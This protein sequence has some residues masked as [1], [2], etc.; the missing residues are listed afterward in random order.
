VLATIHPVLIIWLAIGVAMLI[1]NRRISEATSAGQKAF[2]D[3]L[4]VRWLQRWTDFVLRPWLIRGYLIV[5]AVI[6]IAI[7]TI[8]FLGLFKGSHPRH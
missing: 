1:W 7:S 8:G 4:G 6:W 5:F 3:T 2:A